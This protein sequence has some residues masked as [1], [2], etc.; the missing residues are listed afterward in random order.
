MNERE[1]IIGVLRSLARRL[2]IARAIHEIACA[3]CVVLF[4]LF[5][6]RLVDPALQGQ[7]RW[8]ELMFDFSLL[9]AIG[10][11]ATDAVAH[12]ARRIGASAAAAHADVQAQLKDELKSARCFLSEIQPSALQDLQIRRAAVTAAGLDLA[13]LAPR[14]WQIH[15][16]PVAGLGALLAAVGSMQPGLS[17][18]QEF[19]QGA[20][21]EEHRHLADLR[22][23][24]ENAPARAEIAQ[25]EAA[26]ITLQRPGASAQDKRR[27]LA[28]ARS[29]IEQANMEGSA[30][31]QDLARLAQSLKTDA[32]FEQISRAIEQGHVH[33]ASDLLRAL[34]AD[35]QGIPAEQKAEETRPAGMP[36]GNSLAGEEGAPDESSGKT[37]ALN[38]DSLK[39]VIEA[40][41]QA[42]ERIDVQTRV[43]NVRQRMEDSLNAATQREQLSANHFDNGNEAA[44]PT[45][46]PRT[47]SA[48]IRG[49]TLFHQGVVARENDDSA[50]DGSQTGDAS[51][52]SQALALEGAAVKRLDAQ[53][54]LETILRQD[55][56]GDEPDGKGNAGWFY[57]ASR[58]QKSSLQAEPVQSEVIHQREA[59]LQHERVPIRQ[60]D[61]VKNYFLNL[62][63]SEKK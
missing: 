56:A 15:L 29:A 59:T 8:A 1:T 17:Y 44:N 13:A 58:E 39:R 42:N 20:G 10:A 43:N 38:R 33:D 6:L 25:L 47:G 46:S 51:G 28:E 35:T 21:L 54:K 22:S 60:R 48:D 27:A 19:A 36:D 26:L 37:A 63:E 45:P 34:E 11:I 16:L 62:H 30:A 5:C 23:P 31:R 12:C 24:L 7:A 53:L 9:S 57:S 4:G 2:W 52:E 14:R 61:L 32:R 40:L 18:T 55:E 49:G 3:A 50:R 41:R